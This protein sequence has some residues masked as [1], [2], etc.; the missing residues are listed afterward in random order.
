M[1]KSEE[2]F[3]FIFLLSSDAPTD[4]SGLIITQQLHPIRISQLT[5]TVASA[6]QNVTTFTAASANQNVTTFTAASANQNVT[7]FTAASANQNV[8]INIHCSFSQSECHS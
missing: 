8:T 3:I 7:T 6:Y 5:F 4:G 2:C 1:S